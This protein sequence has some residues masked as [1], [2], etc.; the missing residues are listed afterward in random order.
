MHIINGPEDI[1]LLGV[2]AKSDEVADDDN[3]D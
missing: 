1:I 2:G 3:D